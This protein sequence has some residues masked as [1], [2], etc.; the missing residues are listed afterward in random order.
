MSL[1]HPG[2]S[3]PFRDQTIVEMVTKSL[4]FQ[5]CFLE[6]GMVVSHICWIWLDI[7]DS[8]LICVRIGLTASISVTITLRFPQCSEDYSVDKNKKYD[9]GYEVHSPE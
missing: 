6:P 2:T 7:R 9:E 1:R 8:G 4:Q 5:G 3:A